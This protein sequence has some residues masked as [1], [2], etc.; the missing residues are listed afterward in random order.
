M[1]PP[2][3]DPIARSYRFLEYGS[4]GPALWRRRIAFLPHLSQVRRVLMLGEG[5]GRFLQAF[6]QTNPHAE[7]DYLD[8]SPVMTALA[9]S[10][11]RSPRVRFLTADALT[12]V[13]PQAH[14]DLLVTHFFLDCFGP[15][16][17]PGLIARLA[18]AAQP[19]AQWLVSD[20]RAPNVPSRLLVRALYFFF[21]QTT[22]L[23]PTR[24]TP[25]A[26]FLEQANFRLLQEETS[27]GGL[28]ASELWQRS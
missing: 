11:G 20:F 23:R 27:L 26:P 19:R 28:L 25:Y 13:Y 16:E 1:I 7:V 17:L 8:A 18:L 2:D 9:R 6:L 15:G 10:R 22:G 4:F 12:H 3:F 14:Y 21:A 24:L 5:D